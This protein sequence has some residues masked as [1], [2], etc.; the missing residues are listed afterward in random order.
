MASSRESAQD[1]LT[2]LDVSPSPRDEHPSRLCNGSS[3]LYKHQTLGFEGSLNLSNEPSPRHEGGP[4]RDVEDP[5]VAAY[6]VRHLKLIEALCTAGHLPRSDAMSLGLSEKPW[7]QWA[8]EISERTP[9]A[10]K[11]VLGTANPPTIEEMI[12][13]IPAVD[14]CSDP[15]VYVDA[16]AGKS[17]DYTY[18]GSATGIGGGLRSRKSQHCSFEYRSKSQNQSRH[19]EVIDDPEDPKTPNIRKLLQDKFVSTKKEDL[20]E[21]SVRILLAETEYM[22]W[23]RAFAPWSEWSVATSAYAS[24]CPWPM[25]SFTY[26]GT[27]RS[28]P[29][30]QGYKRHTVDAQAYGYDD[31]KEYDAAWNRNLRRNY[32]EEQAEHERQRRKK[33]RAEVQTPVKYMRAHGVPEDEIKAFQKAKKAERAET[34]PPLIRGRRYQWK[35]TEPRKLEVRDRPELRKYGDKPGTSAT[36]DVI[37]KSMHEDQE[38]SPERS[39]SS[40]SEQ[41]TRAAKAEEGSSYDG[42]TSVIE[43]LSVSEGSSTIKRSSARESPSTME[44]SSA[45]KSASVIRNPS[46]T[47]PA[48]L[49]TTLRHTGASNPTIASKPTRISKLA[50][51]SN[52]L[53]LLGATLT[54]SE[55]KPLRTSSSGSIV[56]SLIGTKR[57]SD[58]KLASS[59]VL[60]KTKSTSINKVR[61]SGPVAKTALPQWLADSSSA[62]HYGEKDKENKSGGSSTVMEDD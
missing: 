51:S 30:Q 22:I 18:V 1:L 29:L 59:K 36:D 39:S 26:D 40:F 54:A 11:R 17:I 38:H 43:R 24:L 9:D 45:M 4:A 3:R 37:Q 23:L 28:V 10:V 2:G 33:Y 60:K 62:P 32:T 35:D 21:L 7:Q 49:T 50:K 12:M 56:Q 61:S 5:L 58:S 8:A 15:G 13:S 25:E 19:Y 47:M 27:N 16:I 31:Q 6:E 46:L 44:G 52:I 41:S 20:D 55:V 53:E 42:D 48:S 57:A 34:F 14:M